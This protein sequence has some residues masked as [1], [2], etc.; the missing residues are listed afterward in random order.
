MQEDCM[1]STLYVRLESHVIRSNE[2]FLAAKKETFQ[3]SFSQPN[4]DSAVIFLQGFFG[5]L[6]SPWIF[7]LFSSS[8]HDDFQS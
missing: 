8:F 4:D 7:L 3:W 5:S 1:T 2:P 6:K